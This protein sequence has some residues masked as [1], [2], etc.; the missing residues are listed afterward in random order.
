MTDSNGLD[1]LGGSEEIEKIM[2]TFNQ[3]MGFIEPITQ[4]HYGGNDEALARGLQ[5]RSA[6]VEET[7][8]LSS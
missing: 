4:T 5:D 1:R 3:N 8:K 6:R 2:N 7:P